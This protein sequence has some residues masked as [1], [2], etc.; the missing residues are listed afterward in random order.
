MLD[1]AK[2]AE[3]TSRG[4]EGLRVSIPRADMGAPSDHETCLTGC[5]ERRNGGSG[6]GPKGREGGGSRQA[7][8]SIVWQG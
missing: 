6:G 1:R 2:A 4:G 7:K 5:T 8:R 3:R